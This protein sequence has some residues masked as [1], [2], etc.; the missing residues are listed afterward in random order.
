MVMKKIYII[1]ICIIE[2]IAL[3]HPETNGSEKKSF[4]RP[5]G[6][7]ND[8]ASVISETEKQVME[9]LCRE[10]LQKTG[11]AIVIATVETIG[12]SDYE[13][14]ANELYAD[15]GIGKKGEDKGVLIFLTKQERKI[16]IETGYGVEGILPDGL[17]GQILDD[18]VVPFLK[19]EEYGKGILNGTFAIAHIIA[20]DAGVKLTGETSSYVPRPVTRKVGVGSQIFSLLFFIIL[21]LILIRNPL[22]LPFL[23]LG[24]GARGV[25]GRGSFGGF[26]GGF[27]GF[28]G[29]LSGGGG[30]G[31][32][33]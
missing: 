33:F 27:G 24:S 18:Q 11:T 26:G 19:R 1:L 29:G 7:V 4:P 8:F 10:V 14:Y 2:I 17:V 25:F 31:R 13:T 32:G 21:F 20:Q 15:W 23:L 5:Y 28:G 3:F 22:L 6:A 30:A 12:D 16:R 9:S